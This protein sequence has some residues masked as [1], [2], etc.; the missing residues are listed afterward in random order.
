MDIYFVNYLQ[1]HLIKISL[2]NIKQKIGQTGKLISLDKMVISILIQ[3]RNRQQ[4]TEQNLREFDNITRRGRS[5][6]RE[7]ERPMSPGASSIKSSRF[8]IQ[9]RKS[10]II[11]CKYNCRSLRELGIDNYPYPDMP[12]ENIK[13][14]RTQER[15]S[16]QNLNNRLAGYIDKVKQLLKIIRINI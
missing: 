11:P 4:M 5:S 16:L 13:L 6:T 15:Q 7:N 3:Q 8:N 9:T 10:Y 14:S 1:D 12:E 2:L